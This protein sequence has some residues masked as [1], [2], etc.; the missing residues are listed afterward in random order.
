MLI[1]TLTRKLISGTYHSISGL[2]FA[3]RE[4]Q[5][6]RLEAILCILLIPLSLW[7]GHTKIEKA[8]LFFVWM[9]VP[10][11]ELLNSA[12]ENAINRISHERHPLSRRAKDMGS[13]AVFVAS[14]TCTMVW[15]VVLFC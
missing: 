9:L 15:V 5:A 7:L 12:I 10:L 13:A 8:L 11:V 1:R 3:F 4:E 6:F 14:L 2:L